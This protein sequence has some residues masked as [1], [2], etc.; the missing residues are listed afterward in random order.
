M[1]LALLTLLPMRR[2]LSIH[3]KPRTASLIDRDRTTSLSKIP[4]SDAPTIGRDKSYASSL[5]V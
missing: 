2:F 5:C 3:E 1:A 4:S